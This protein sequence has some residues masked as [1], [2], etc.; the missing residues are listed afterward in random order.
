[1]RRIEGVGQERGQ[2]ISVELDGDRVPAFDGEPVALWLLAAGETVFARSIKYHRPRGPYCF[3]AACS[4]CLMRVDG[5]PNI[6][7]C[8]TPARAGM[9]LDRQNAY[10]SV[11]VDVFRSIDWLFPRGLDHHAMFAGVP[12]AE[13]VMAKVARHLPGLGTL[14]NEAAP[15]RLPCVTLTTQVA[16]AG[17]GA[18]G[19]TI[20]SML[21]GRGV[22]FQLIE[23]EDFL[24]G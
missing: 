8:R 18:S 12:V 19:S 15:P 7:T 2:A 11:K 10:P 13:Q 14:P 16:I 23:R 24:G 17:G 21:A 5:V 1:M 9:R 4:H 6:Y 20:G 3:A 22:P